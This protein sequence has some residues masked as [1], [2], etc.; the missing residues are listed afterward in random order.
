LKSSL[1]FLFCIA[2]ILVACSGQATPTLYVPAEQVNFPVANT[3]TTITTEEVDSAL[4]S[5]IPTASPDCSSNLL[6]LQ[7]ITIPD[8]TQ[9][10]PEER[11]DKRWLVENDGTCNWDRRYS[12]RLIAGLDMGAGP[13][14]ALFPA[15][16]GSQVEIQIQFVAPQDIGL[17]RSAWQAADPGGNLFGDTIFIEIEV[18][19]P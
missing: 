3:P 12:L 18:S 5:Q 8:G 15:R 4:D 19:N 16:S 11:L 1:I 6:F 10:Q 13:D 7:D 2:L 14:L 9:V 17:H